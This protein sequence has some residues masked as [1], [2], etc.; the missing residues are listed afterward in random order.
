MRST[1]AYLGPLTGYQRRLRHRRIHELTVSSVLSQGK[2]PR[3]EYLYA[4]QEIERV[5]S[6]ARARSGSAWW[7]RVFRRHQQ[8]FEIVCAD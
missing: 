5:N 3:L 1:G 4:D 2:G 8:L 6:R 7:L